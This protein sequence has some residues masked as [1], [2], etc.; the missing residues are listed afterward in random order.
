MR[1]ILIIFSIVVAL[2]GCIAI[3]ATSPNVSEQFARVAKNSSQFAATFF[4]PGA[5]VADLQR[6]YDRALRTRKPVRIL[7]VPGHEPAFGGAEYRGIKERDI[8]LALA[9]QLQAYLG[10][11]Q[12][13]EVYL[14]R[15]ASGW[16]PTLLNYFAD[17]WDEIQIFAE[18][19]KIDMAKHIGAGT[20]TKHDPVMVH[21]T[22]PSDVGRRLYGIHKWAN[23][24]EMD[25]TI[26]IH[27]N[28]NPRRN[29]SRPG[30]Y[31]G[32]TIYIPDRQYSNSATARDVAD[33]I[34]ARL[35]TQ[36]PPSTMP[37]EAPGIVE[38]QDLIAIGSYN[39]SDAPSIL[40][41]YAY[42]YEPMLQ[43]AAARAS[44]LQDMALQTHAGIQDFFEN[45]NKSL[46]QNSR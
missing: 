16:N 4:V 22:A 25:I 2:G 29:T 42:I 14:S 46:V 5:S 18:N 15:D 9:T 31:F 30:D 21:N 13:Y 1:R 33:S 45:K 36:Y 43:D 40:I 38:S 8:A 44:V 35:S 26:H 12:R 10:T 24:N 41:E 17:N 28:D 20:L 7:L 34:F 39:T 23:E 19:Q 32:F 3:V 37:K 6:K 27:F 11:N